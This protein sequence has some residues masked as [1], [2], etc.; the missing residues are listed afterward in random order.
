MSNATPYSVP[1]EPGRWRGALLALV[2][3]IALFAFLWFGVR[4]QNET[5]IAIEAEVWSPQVREAA[6]RPQPEPE[7]IEKPEPKPVIHEQPKP[8]AIEPPVVKPDIALEQE[9][10]RKA[11][12]Q[13]QREDEARLEKQRAEEKKQEEKRKEKEKLDAKLQK[14][15][16]E[17]RVKKEAAE[18]KHLQDVADEQRLEKLRQEEMRRITSGVSGSGGSGDAPKS[19]GSRGD[20]SYGQ[21]VGAKIKSNTVFNVPDNMSGESAVEYAVELLPDG[22]LRG[23]RKLKSSGVP[24][25]DEAVKRAIEKSAPYPPDKTGSVPSSFNLVH[26]PKDQ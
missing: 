17:E 9:K 20:A 4:W 16:A 23:L 18:K 13:K 25:F 1:Q 12:E 21:K 14:K 19:Q 7:A 24:G 5:P 11:K 8:V 22:S 15:L 6:P 2:V 3:H 26:K 10:K